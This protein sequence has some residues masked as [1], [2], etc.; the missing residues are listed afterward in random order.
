MP[1]LLFLCSIL[2]CL[3]GSYQDFDAVFEKKLAESNLASNSELMDLSFD[4]GLYWTSGIEI[5][6]NS[7]ELH[8]NKTWL[9]HMAKVQN[10]RNGYPDE[11]TIRP[12]T[13][14]NHPERWMMEV[15]NSSLTMRSFGLD[16]GMAGTTICLV[17]GS[18]VEVIDGELLSNMECSGFVLAD[19]VGSGSSRIVIVGS[20]HKSSTLNVVLPLV[21]RGSG[22]LNT[23]EETWKGVEE[24]FGDGCVER[25]EIIGVGLSF[26][27]TH[28]VL[29]TGPLFS[30]VGK[31][32]WSG[33]ENA[34]IGMIGE[35]STELRLSSI[36]NVTS[37]FGSRTGL[38]VGSCVWER[39][40][41]SRVSGSTNHDMGTGL[42][43]PR[44]G[45]N[46]FCVNSSFSSCV[47]TSNAVVDH[48]HKNITSTNIK[49]TYVTQESGMTS[50]K[51]TL[52]TFNDM[53]SPGTDNGQGGAA[54]C[55][56][57]SQSNL[58]VTQ[59][60]FHKCLCTSPNDAGAAIRVWEYVE[61]CPITL[62]LSSFTE[63]ISRGTSG[64]YGG[65]VSCASNSTISVS[66]CFVEKSTSGT[67]HGAVYLSMFS[68]AT[69]SNCAF[70]SC[71]CPY[72]G[73]ALGPQS[74]KAI[75][76]SFL[77]F[78]KC[79]STSFGKG[80]DIYFSS[81]YSSLDSSNVLFCDST[82]GTLNVLA[83]SYDLSALVPQLKSTPTMTA[84]VSFSGD[85]ATVTATATA[86]VKGTVGILLEGSNVPR[87][88]YVPFGKDSDTSSTGTAVVSSGA[89]GVLPQ[90]TYS[91]RASSVPSH[92]VSSLTISSVQSTF[93]DGYSTTI[94]VS[95]EH[96]GEGRYTMVISLG[97]HFY[98]VPL[99]FSSTKTLVGVAPLRPSTGSGMLEWE[100]E[101][102]VE[103]VTWHA[104]GG[105]DVDVTLTNTISFTT[106]IQPPRIHSLLFCSLT[107]TKDGLT[108]LFRGALL[109]AGEGTI[110]FKPKDSDILVEGVLTS[111]STAQRTAVMPS[112]WTE[113][114]THLEY[115]KSYCIKSV[116]CNS[117]EILNY[118]TDYFVV[119]NPPVITSFIVPTECSSD[120]FDI[121]VIGENLPYPDTY[122]LTLDNAHTIS[123]TFSDETAGTGTVKASLPTE[124]QFGRTYTVSSVVN[125]DDHVLFNQTSFTSPLGPT[126][127]SIST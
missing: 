98:D 29:G 86:G 121:E 120:S 92:N 6:S 115:G 94:L 67:Y 69:L 28:F 108:L 93:K 71:S 20:S 80:K 104:H 26:D 100:V 55:L 114:T 125:G 59:C 87:L 99:T 95:G 36:L 74:V 89:D 14:L 64:S 70:V 5:V 4:D 1:M 72:Y 102:S 88:V 68:L 75:E 41:G 34:K 19:S 44:L 43:G 63:C 57:K 9:T 65:S 97:N 48:K 90:A 53:T 84:K 61:D 56:Y 47:R 58:T 117:V 49:R 22:Q 107:T 38:G 46:V 50:V 85:T 96:L 103:R 32:L 3:D 31:S 76:L 18:S 110:R 118:F 62:S 25:E 126:L 27:S 51:F 11:S 45:F 66:D 83:N 13:K 7:V 40:V 105:V 124:V 109:P 37:N 91:L 2:H 79:S 81:T 17:V 23:I 35:I 42:C 73:G 24:G 101:Y 78:R 52:C 111:D 30:F 82:S 122:T 116:V 16:A 77:Q 33:S 12:T 15:R 113:N 106:P 21:G 112:T 123:I 10:E 119:P 8:G 60:F 127:T 39:V 54:I